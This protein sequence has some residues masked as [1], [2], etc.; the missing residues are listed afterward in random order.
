LIETLN[1]IRKEIRIEAL[2]ITEASFALKK[3]MTTRQAA[4]LVVALEQEIIN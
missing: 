2:N 3:F 1:N 4:N